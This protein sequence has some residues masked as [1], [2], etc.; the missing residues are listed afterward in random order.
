MAWAWLG[1]DGGVGICPVVLCSGEGTSFSLHFR[2]LPHGSF[3]WEGLLWK[4]G[5]PLGKGGV[6]SS[7][8]GLR[9]GTHLAS[10]V[11]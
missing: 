4:G 7:S 9:D 8:Q 3:A 11:I 5:P 10:I 2:T 1:R 6:S